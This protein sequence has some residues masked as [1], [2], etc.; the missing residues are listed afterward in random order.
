MHVFYNFRLIP[1]YHSPTIKGHDSV[2]QK[3]F[4]EVLNFAKEYHS[5]LFLQVATMDAIKSTR[6]SHPCLNPPWHN[7]LIFTE[8][9]PT[10]ILDMLQIVLGFESWLEEREG[11]SIT[12]LS[13][14]QQ[15]QSTEQKLLLFVFFSSILYASHRKSPLK[16]EDYLHVAEPKKSKSKHEE[17]CTVRCDAAFLRNTIILLHSSSRN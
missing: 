17:G 15:G 12:H 9:S 10:C 8:S 11:F 1:F 16:E 13:P 5:F 6:G 7:T 4:G 2:E 14:L 3:I